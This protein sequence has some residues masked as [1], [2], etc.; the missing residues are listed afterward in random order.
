[1][2]RA[3]AERLRLALLGRPVEC[4]VCGRRIARLAFVTR[5]GRVRLLGVGGAVLRVRFTDRDELAFEHADSQIC[6]RRLGT[7]LPRPDAPAG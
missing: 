3:R 1:M 4:R 2:L 6:E 7:P 5:G